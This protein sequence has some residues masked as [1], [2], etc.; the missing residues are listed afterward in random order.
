MPRHIVLVGA[1]AGALL[2]SGCMMAGGMGSGMMGGLDSPRP[3]AANAVV[4][5][6]RTSDVHVTL[7]FPP[8]VAGNEGTF[9]VGVRD[10]SGRPISSALVTLR[11]RRVDEDTGVTL[12]A[13][14]SSPGSALYEATHRFSAAGSYAATAEV[15]IDARNPGHV[16]SVT[17]RQ[18]IIAAHSPSGGGSRAVPAAIVGGVVM[19]GM[20]L[21][22]LVARRPF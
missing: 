7:E 11:V 18:D 15:A 22:M 9:T 20:V 10:A 6:A 2:S 13:A 19:A 17:A 8:V 12:Q 4:A 1:L 16:V 14:Q 5:E 21:W 3:P